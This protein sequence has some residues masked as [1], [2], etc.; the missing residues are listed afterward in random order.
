MT[1]LDAYHSFPIAIKRLPSIIAFSLSVYT[2]SS[3][4]TVIPELSKWISG[5]MRFKLLHDFH[6]PRAAD[7]V[8]MVAFSVRSTSLA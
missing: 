8:E 1:V 7:P 3:H 2:F 4:R 6:F 5:S